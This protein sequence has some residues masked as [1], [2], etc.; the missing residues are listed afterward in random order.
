MRRIISVILCICMIW[1][2]IPTNVFASENDEILKMDDSSDD[3]LSFGEIGGFLA[4]NIETVKKVHENKLFTTRQGHGFAAE[5][6]N[7]LY[8]SYKGS[9]GNVVGDDFMKNG[10]DRAIINR[11]GS[12]ILIQ[13]KYYQSAK[14]TVEAA[15]DENGVYKYVDADGM[16]MLLEVPKDQFDDAV[17]LIEDKIKDGKIQNVTD[18]KEAS[19]IVKKGNVTYKQAVNIAKA[20]NIDSLV[21][22]ATNGIV[23]ASCAAG[24][25]FVLD[26]A[27]S[28]MNGLDPVMAL[29]NAIKSGLKTGGFVFATFV[30]SSQLAR[31]GVLHAFVPTSEAITKALG[32]EVCEAILKR[33]GINVT[34]LTTAQIT[35]KVTEILSKE[36]L[37][38]AV[39]I[40]VLTAADVTEL[41][42]GRISKEELLKNLTVAIVVAAASTA[43][44]YVGGAAGNVV[45]PGAGAL[46]G[47]IAGGTLVGGV[48]G[49]AS[50]LVADKIYKSDADEMFE[51]ISTE[52]QNLGEDY[53]INEDEATLI[54]DELSLLL[55]DDILKDMYA[56]EDRC[57][58]AI[59][60][61]K[62]LFEKQ[63]EARELITIPTENQIR[64]QYKTL[65]TDV[66]FIH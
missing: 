14:K 35:T 1:S 33:T 20:G 18:P 24:I 49:L 59:D 58:F 15:F 60:L 40:V 56:S 64:Y 39:V 4:G 28:R 3:T 5:R 51:I 37:T 22:D 48:A 50:E 7:N 17:K 16:P 11:N 63:I 29:D 57:E 41:F 43:G 23:S 25:G 42:R 53:L 55:K 46:I 27:V 45:L 12:T 65:M 2:A 36:L 62:P 34:G 47:T 30:I 8:D 38:E 66:V 31:T 44:G 13:D 21:Y 6:A 52:F 19:N 9:K 26:Y 32:P 54:S 10:P 61:L